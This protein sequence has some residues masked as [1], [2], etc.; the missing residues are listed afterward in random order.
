MI[1]SLLLPTFSNNHHHGAGF[2]G[3]PVEAKI[4]RLERS[5]RSNGTRTPSS[6]IVGSSGENCS[7]FALIA[8]EG[9]PVPSLRTTFPSCAARDLTSVG[10]MPSTSTL[11]FAQNSHMRS[12]VG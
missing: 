1:G 10:D 9:V 12:G 3:S 6:A 11:C 2:H 7:C 5:W 8:D 4:R